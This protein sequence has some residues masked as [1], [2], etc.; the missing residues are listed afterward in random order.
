MLVAAVA[1]A[2]AGIVEVWRLKVLPDSDGDGNYKPNEAAPITIF[3]Q[4]RLRG[5]D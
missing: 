4:V 3:W 1:M 5:E 2:Y